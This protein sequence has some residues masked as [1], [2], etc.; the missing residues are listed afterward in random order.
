MHLLIVDVV[1]KKEKIAIGKI[2]PYTESRFAAL[3]KLTA[4]ERLEI[5]HNHYEENQFKF[6]TFVLSTKFKSTQ[7]L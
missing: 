2:F 4:R 7:L 5:F 6:E 3:N 1:T